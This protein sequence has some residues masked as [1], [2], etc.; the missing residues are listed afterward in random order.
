MFKHGPLC[1]YWT[2][3]LQNSPRAFRSCRSLRGS[4]L[5]STLQLAELVDEVSDPYKLAQIG[6]RCTHA[7]TTAALE[8]G[9]E[10]SN[11]L[12][13]KPSHSMSYYGGVLHGFIVAIEQMYL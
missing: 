13:L 9:I 8:D 3:L 7:Q 4:R 10:T 2:R 6:I 11:L 1:S 12:W 5:L